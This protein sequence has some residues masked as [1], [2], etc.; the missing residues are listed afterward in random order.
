MPGRQQKRANQ[1]N[2]ALWIT[3]GL[4]QLPQ[5]VTLTEMFGLLAMGN[6]TTWTLQDDF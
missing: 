2:I 6:E 3:F 5:N 1:V 4:I